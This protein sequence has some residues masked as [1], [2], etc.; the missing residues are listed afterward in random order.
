MNDSKEGYVLRIRQCSMEIEK[1]GNLG[2][3]EPLRLEMHLAELQAFRSW[4]KIFCE[5]VND[6][7]RGCKMGE[8]GVI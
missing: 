4:S 1:T 3:R 6:L 2:K 8:S 5:V 7:L